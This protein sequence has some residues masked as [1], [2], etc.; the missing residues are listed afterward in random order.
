MNLR[1]KI[2]KQ[3][4]GI[5]LAFFIATCIYYKKTEVIDKSYERISIIKKSN[6]EN[7][8]KEY[9]DATSDKVFKGER[10]RTFRNNH[11]KFSDNK[12]ITKVKRSDNFSKNCT[13]WAVVTTIYSPPQEAIRRFFY[14]LDWCVVVVGDLNKPKV[15][16][17]SKK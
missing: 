14:R 8:N 7:Y 9:S 17:R 5:L 16:S 12:F 6:E 3:I 10:F 13:K 11:R 2:C 15:K 4:F 1:Q